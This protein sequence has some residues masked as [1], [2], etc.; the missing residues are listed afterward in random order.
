MALLLLAGHEVN[1]GRLRLFARRYRD[2][3][4]AAAGATTR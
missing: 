2:D 3:L 4:I 1:L